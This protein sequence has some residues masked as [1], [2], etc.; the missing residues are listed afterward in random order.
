MLVDPLDPEVMARGLARLLSD[1]HLRMKL[2]E[3][4]SE[5]LKRFSWERAAEEVLNV[6]R[7]V[8]EPR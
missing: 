1:R 5:N 7:E 3:Q 4:G 8:V 2:A 6:C